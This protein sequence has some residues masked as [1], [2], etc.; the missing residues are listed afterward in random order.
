[1]DAEMPQSWLAALRTS[2]NDPSQLHENS[3]PPPPI[4][5]E[6]FGSEY[7]LYGFVVPDDLKDAYNIK[8]NFLGHP[9]EY[10]D[11]YSRRQEYTRIAIRDAAK[12]LGLRVFIDSPPECNFT[13]WFSCAKHGKVQ[14]QQV[15]VASKLEQFAAELGIKQKAGWHKTWV[16]SQACR[17]SRNLEPPSH[18]PQLR[19]ADSNFPMDLVDWSAPG[20]PPAW[21]AFL[22]A[23]SAG[24]YSAQPTKRS[25]DTEPTPAI[26]PEL[27]GHGYVLY[28][29]LMIV[30]Q[31]EALATKYSNLGYPEVYSDKEYRRQSYTRIAVHCTARNLGMKVHIH[32]QPYH[33]FIAYF[34]SARRD[35]ISIRQIPVASK[36]EEFANEMGIKQKPRWH[37]ARSIS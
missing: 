12:K 21:Q 25:Y 28:G 35:A 11:P 27:V 6:L 16:P 2:S 32:S 15:P 37:Q 14:V 5:S 34:S 17:T 8:Y 31:M 23:R 13:V 29:Y 33:D 30:E 7:V 24:A 10:S 18:V 1:M 19:Q 20:F 4:P 26:P 22:D 36:L 9:N 3:E